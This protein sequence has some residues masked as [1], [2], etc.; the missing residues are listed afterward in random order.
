M[1][2]KMFI[3][4]AALSVMVSTP[5]AAHERNDRERHEHREERVK[6]HRH[7][8]GGLLGLITG[9]LVGSAVS[10]VDPY[11][12]P[13]YRSYPVSPYIP[14]Y[15]PYRV[16]EYPYNQYYCVTEQQVDRYGRVYHIRRCNY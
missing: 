2:K 12:Y 1:I 11:Y 5:T 6:P 10:E 3:A 4:L 14:P 15:E 7:G 13:R 8:S 16:N 9:I